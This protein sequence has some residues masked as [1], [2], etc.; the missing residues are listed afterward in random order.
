MHLFRACFATASIFCS[1]YGIR[2]LALVDA[3]IL[4]NTL[5]LFIPLVIWIWHGEKIDR[6]CWMI[7]LIGFS[8]LFFILKPQCNILHLA[9]FA[10]LGTALASAISAVSIKTLSKTE[11]PLTILF[12]FTVF[13]GLITF[14]PCYQHW[15]NVPMTF[16]FW[17]PF[18]VISLFGVG[19]QYAITR[20]YT[21]MPAHI[22]GSFIYFS[23]L[24]S[25]LFGWIFWRERVDIMQIVGATILIGTGLFMLRNNSKSFPAHIESIASKSE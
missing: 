25:A 15:E 24:Y 16:S 22:V 9:S 17:W 23:V 4:E 12:F 21:L 20:A 11:S 6:T 10:S 8:S 18:I 5:P 19:F 3:V 14:F 13:S 2:H 1:I 7:L